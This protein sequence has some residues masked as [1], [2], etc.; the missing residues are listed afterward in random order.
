[1]RINVHSKNCKKYQNKEENKMAKKKEQKDMAQEQE[2]R[3]KFQQ[4]LIEILE[5][6]KK[7]K[8]M[9][10]YQEIADFSRT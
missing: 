5:L 2:L 1:M 10:E 9:L 6:G 3:L 7:K 8:N 4:K